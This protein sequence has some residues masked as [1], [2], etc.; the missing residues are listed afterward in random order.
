MAGYHG[1]TWGLAQSRKTSSRFTEF[2]RLTR[3]ALF[4][5]HAGERT[6]WTGFESINKLG[7]TA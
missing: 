5:I 2:T 4:C 1:V 3:L 7:A 6:F